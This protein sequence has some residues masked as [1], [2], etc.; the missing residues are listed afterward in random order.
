[1]WSTEKAF[2]ESR[3]LN[4]GF[5]LIELLVV[6]AI[7]AILAAIAIPQYNKY[8]ANA[9]L[10]NVQQAAKQAATLAMSGATGASQHPE[11]RFDQR[12]IASYSNNKITITN[13]AGTI[14]DVVEMWTDTPGWVASLT[15]S[16]L[17]L[18]T[19]GT[20]VAITGNGYIEVVSNFSFGGTPLG[21]R[22]YPTN[23]SLA[24]AT[25]ARCSLP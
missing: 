16:N 22:Y 2:E 20:G 19:L 5:T 23:D 25:S 13:T 4:K 14:C 11:C 10:S 24:D 12:F 9:M 1:M 17:T 21:C 8:R 15:A 18:E 3:R 7:I 6:M